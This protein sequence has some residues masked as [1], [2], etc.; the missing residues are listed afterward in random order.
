MEQLLGSTSNVEDVGCKYDLHIQSYGTC[1]CII[2]WGPTF[3]GQSMENHRHDAEVDDL[4]IVVAKGCNNVSN[5]S[6]CL[7]IL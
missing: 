3:S 2:S 5:P 6:S 4:Q 7:S 1:F